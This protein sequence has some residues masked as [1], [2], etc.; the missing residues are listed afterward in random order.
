M[1][2]GSRRITASKLGT[3]YKRHP[4]DENTI[5]QGKRKPKMFVQQYEDL[6]KW[7][8]ATV[9]VGFGYIYC[10]YI[11][12]GSIRS[13]DSDE[14]VY[15]KSINPTYSASNGPSAISAM[16]ILVYLGTNDA[17]KERV[18]QFMESLCRITEKYFLE[19]R[20]Y[21]QMCKTAWPILS[22]TALDVKVGYS[23]TRDSFSISATGTLSAAKSFIDFMKDRVGAIESC[24]LKI[25]ANKQGLIG[26]LY[27]LRQ[28]SNELLAGE[29]DKVAAGYTSCYY[30]VEFPKTFKSVVISF[31]PPW[32]I[33]VDA[34]DERQLFDSLVATMKDVIE[35]Y[36]EAV[37]HCR[38]FRRG[39]NTSEVKGKFSLYHANFNKLNGNFF[40]CGDS[41]SVKAAFEWLTVVPTAEK[42][43]SQI[44]KV[45]DVRLVFMLRNSRHAKV[46]DE[47]KKAVVEGGSRNV[48]ITEL[49]YFSALFGVKG[50]STFVEAAIS[51]GQSFIS[52][53]VA[54]FLD[55]RLLGPNQSDLTGSQINFLKTNEGSYLMKKTSNEFGISFKYVSAN[56]S[57]EEDSQNVGATSIIELLFAK[58]GSVEIRVAHGDML[59]V[60]C[61]T[62]VNPANSRLAHGAG[63]ARAI[64]EAA[65]PELN[66]QCED[67]LKRFGG[68]LPMSEAV[69][70]DSYDLKRFNQNSKIVV[71]SVGP[72]YSTGSSSEIEYYQQAIM[73]SLD[74]AVENGAV[75][76]AMPLIGSGVFGWPVELAAR[77]MLGAI[78]K[79]VGAGNSCKRIIL[80]DIE[81]NRAAAMVQTVQLFNEK[82]VPLLLS[83]SKKAATATATVLKVP[84]FSWYWEVYSHEMDPQGNLLFNHPDTIVTA[85]GAHWVPYDYDQVEIS[86]KKF[87]YLC[88]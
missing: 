22:A 25:P 33:N 6:F 2:N 20:V 3:F 16:V 85:G 7:E 17:G 29:G 86:A 47:L 56:N 70:T 75:F 23:S 73:N 1:V 19:D 12:P 69:V 43:I 14:A 67:I 68:E 26:L 40:F 4:Q 84:Q 52:R 15:K 48:V 63:A 32:D 38:L 5:K 79:W 50:P 80:V 54:N 11:D 31:L 76:I 30:E 18:R 71:H 49:V 60:E 42:E 74:K 66:A 88:F 81:E 55:R 58:I 83:D 41:Q 10:V 82:V 62:I 24:L 13:P 9:E 37:C 27:G 53:L 21:I 44:F 57:S 36:D 65:G 35:S 8:D 78:S 28:K 39:I 59:R 64:S 77:E 46:L 87:N 45:S 51:E 34:N 72:K 61:D